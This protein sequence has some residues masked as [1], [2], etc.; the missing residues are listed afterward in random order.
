M[1]ECFHNP[2]NSDMDYG[3]FNVHTDVNACDCTRGCTDTVR[4]SPMHVDPGGKNP[5]PH[6]ESN[7]RRRR[8]GPMLH[9]LNY[10]RNQKTVS[11]GNPTFLVCLPTEEGVYFREECCGVVRRQ[12]SDTFVATQ[13]LYCL[14]PDI[15]RPFNHEC[16]ISQRS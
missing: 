6:R 8:A 11:A 14:L 2:P 5:L 12:K 4:E 15:Q 3:I 13:R 10:I 1:F 16:H 9:Q 7:L